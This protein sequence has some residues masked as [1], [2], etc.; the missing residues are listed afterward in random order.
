MESDNNKD[1]KIESHLL[2]LSID[3]KLDKHDIKLDILANRIHKIEL[4]QTRTEVD[5]EHHIKRTDTL[6]KFVRAN[7]SYL[8]KEIELLEKK[9]KP[10]ELTASTISKFV[11]FL[12]ALSAII[13]VIISVSK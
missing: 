8:K 13:A 9:T 2:L 10:F 6:E 11:I 3:K 12:S 4:S 1:L 7:D 5:I